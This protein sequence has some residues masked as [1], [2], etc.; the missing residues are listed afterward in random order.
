MIEKEFKFEIKN[1]EEV[2]GKIG[3][4][5]PEIFY[6]RDEIYGTKLGYQ[7]GKIRK[8]MIISPK[9]I[10]ISFEKTK[11]LETRNNINRSKE[12]EIKEIPKGYQRESSYD[13]IRFYFRRPKYRISVDIYFF[14]MFC[15]IEGEERI[16]R[17]VAERLGFKLKDNL[18]DNVDRLYCQWAKKNKRRELFHWGFGKL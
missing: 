4:A 7:E 5:R 18:K 13:K 3:G 14:G 9:G 2:I 12:E 1:I 17:K 15:E 8:R 16:I 10:E 11:L 6:C